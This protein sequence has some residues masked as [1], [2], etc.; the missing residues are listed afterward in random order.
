MVLLKS[1][2]LIALQNFLQ[3]PQIPIK[4]ISQ[5]TW[6]ISFTKN[7]QFS[8]KTSTEG[9]LRGVPKTRFW[10]PPLASIFDYF[11]GLSQNENENLKRRKPFESD[12]FL[13][14]CCLQ[15]QTAVTVTCFTSSWKMTTKNVPQNNQNLHHERKDFNLV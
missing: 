11:G 5:V 12:A 1:Q 7:F 13:L 3:G 8:R 2:I 4:K 14:C 15:V 9:T 6:W 10:Y